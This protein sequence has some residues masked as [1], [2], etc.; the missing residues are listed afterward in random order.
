MVPTA[1]LYRTASGNSAAC[2]PAAT[3]GNAVVGSGTCPP[4]RSW[5]S[6]ASRPARID[7]V[8]R[9]RIRKAADLL[10]ALISRDHDSRYP[11][12]RRGL[13]FSARIASCR[14]ALPD[15][16]A[17]LL[18]LPVPPGYISVAVRRCSSAADG[19][20]CACAG[21]P[22]ANARPSPTSQHV[23]SP[24][25]FSFCLDPRQQR[26]RVDHEGSMDSSRTVRD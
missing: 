24:L 22:R 12:E 3:G 11:A 1:L 17:W 20:C 7:G 13:R 9:Q 15:L 4:M 26:Q 19:F 6:G 18:P 10:V 25:T 8:H 23:S 16:R 21:T 14:S 5:V 2:R